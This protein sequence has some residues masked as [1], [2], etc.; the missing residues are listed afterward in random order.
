MQLVKLFRKDYEVYDLAG[1]SMSLGVGYEVS[2]DFLH[3]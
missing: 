2:K 1:G 3:F